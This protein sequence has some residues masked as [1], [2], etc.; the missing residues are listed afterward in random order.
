MDQNQEIFDTKSRVAEQEEQRVLVEQLIHT[1]RQA[2]HFAV[3]PFPSFGLERQFSQPMGACL[4]AVT[5]KTL[6]I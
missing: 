5:L 2:I 4:T 3:A 6:C 1:A